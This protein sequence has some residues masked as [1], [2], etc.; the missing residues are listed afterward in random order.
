MI[1]KN[2]N[3]YPNIYRVFVNSEQISRQLKQEQ[4]F[5]IFQCSFIICPYIFDKIKN[6]KVLF[7][8]LHSKGLFDPLELDDVDIFISDNCVKFERNRIT[9]KKVIAKKGNE[10]I[11]CSEFPNTLYNLD[12]KLLLLFIT[13]TNFIDY[14]Y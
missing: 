14:R 12:K 9:F 4:Y 2:T 7:D 13:I 6:R 10:K 1:K 5:D 8:F 3:N 11:F